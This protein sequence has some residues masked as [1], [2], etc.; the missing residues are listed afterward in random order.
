[1]NI[2]E[3]FPILETIPLFSQASPDH[4]SRCFTEEDWKLFDFGSGDILCS[5]DTAPVRVGVLLSG[6]AEIYT[7]G[8]QMRTL[9]KTAKPGEV[10]GIANLYA[11]D[12]AFPTIIRA[13]GAVRVLFFSAAAFRC[14][15]ETDEK[16][17]RFYLRFLSKK[18]VY[19]NR[20]IATFTA[21]SAE[22]RLAL[23]LL[24]NHKL[25][26]DSPAYS[27]T[28]LADLLGLGRAS[29]YRAVDKLVELS[30][31]THQNGRIA[32]LDPGALSD[33]SQSL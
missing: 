3:Q 30:L 16:L 24:E 14:F 2:Y 17:L 27:M 9:L 33:F 5:S 11:T 21:G 19:L 26:I 29:L 4:A 32:L 1:M 22:H 25:G 12:D 18:I 10:F 23:F 6:E 31:I 15:I 13:K 28:K 7:Q 20:K 8:T